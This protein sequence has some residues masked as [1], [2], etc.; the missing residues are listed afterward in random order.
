MRDIPSG[1]SSPNLA[2]ARLE[3]LAQQLTQR[4]DVTPMYGGHRRYSYRVHGAESRYN[5]LLTSMEPAC[6]RQA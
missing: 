5:Y 4:V 1:S 2:V 3:C 6:Q